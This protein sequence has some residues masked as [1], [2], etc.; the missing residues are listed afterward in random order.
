MEEFTVHKVAGILIGLALLPGLCSASPAACAPSVPAARIPRAPKLD[1]SLRDACWREAQWQSGF[2]QHT[3]PEEPAVHDTR[4]AFAVDDRFLYVAA[5]MTEPQPQKLVAQAK[6]HDAKVYR[7][8]CLQVFIDPDRSDGEYFVFSFNSFGTIRDNK[9][10]QAAWSSDARAAAQ[11]SGGAWSVEAAIPLGDLEL[12]LQ[13][14]QKPW[15]V[16]VSRVRRAGGMQELSTFVPIRGTF[17]QPKRFTPLVVPKE[18]LTPY[19]WHISP[20]DERHVML[21]GGQPVLRADVEVQN[22]TGRFRRFLLTAQVR[23][24]SGEDAGEPVPDSLDGTEKRIFDLAAP[25]AGQKEA[26]LV[27]S[28]HD[29]LDPRRLLA[30]RQWRADVTYTPISLTMTTPWYKNAIFATQQVTAVELDV[31]SDLPADI[32]AGLDLVADVRAADKIAAGPVRVELAGCDAAVSLPAAR[33]PVGDYQVRVALVDTSGKA[34]HEATTRLRKLPPHE[35]EVRFDREGAPLVDGKPFLP[36]GWFGVHLDRLE[37]FAAEGYTLVGAYGPTCTS[38][39]DDYVMA[40]LDKAHELGMKVI[41]R[42][43]P[44]YE[45]VRSAHRLLTEEEA[46]AMRALVRKWRDHPAVVG[47]YMCDE[48]EGR[49]E[50]L[51]RRLQEYRIVDEEDPYHPAIVL[52]NTTD[53]IRKYHPSGDLL[54][55]DVY[56]GFLRK[57][58]ASYISRPVHAMIACREATDGRKPVW[59]TPQG[60]IQVVGGHRGPTFRELRNQA[61][62]GAAG[63]AMGFFWYREVFR[64]NLVPSKIGTPYIHREMAAI[65]MALRTKSIPGLANA[66]VRTDQLV[67]AGKR[68]GGHTYIISVSLT[69]DDMDVTV[70]VMGVGDRPLLVLSEGRRVF[71]RGD[72]FRDRFKPYEAH[73]YTT[74]LSLSA[75]PTAAEVEALIQKEIQA[76]HKPG[77]L[78]YQTTV[79]EIVPQHHDGQALFLNDGVVDGVYWPREWGGV[80]HP[81]PNWVDVQLPKP[82]QVGRVVVYSVRGGDEP[83][84]FVA[85]EVQVMREGEWTPVAGVTDNRKEPATITF[86]PVRTDRLRLLITGAITG[87]ITLQEIEVYAE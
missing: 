23:S 3:D 69:W 19:I 78:A 85:G 79:A 46:A 50:P 65:E 82:Q 10:L 40:Y 71:P 81:L 77:N 56:P 43:Q 45:V 22:L 16:N 63:D 47:W 83:A 27:V 24:E 75:L 80:S 59:I 67:L 58:G 13:A 20:P 34:V 87:R 12:T 35:G 15:G 30:R 42:P 60:Q 48:P 52:N 70:D 51:E 49:S 68:A 37:E 39:D 28:L 53:G 25:T 31:H 61:W 74:D 29:A 44:N 72:R 5:E 8:D 6:E 62:Q 7:D 55:P 76:R 11:V 57:S 36:F 14:S 33:L 4:F 38:A 21:E 64:E 2:R 41:C 17:H 9:G 32:L 54:M 1:G 66:D 73:V 86:L 84:S 26:M 18:V